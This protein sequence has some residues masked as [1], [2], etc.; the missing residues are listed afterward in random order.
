MYSLHFQ[1]S[2]NNNNYKILL[3]GFHWQIHN[4]LVFMIKM[5]KK[6]NKFFTKFINY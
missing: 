2:R 5:V 6:K 4:L 3:N 1:N